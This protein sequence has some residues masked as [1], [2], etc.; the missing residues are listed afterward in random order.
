M[1]IRA[2]IRTAALATL[3][4]SGLVPAHAAD[5]SATQVIQVAASEGTSRFVPLGVGK[6]V[7]I[8]LPRDIKDVLVANPKIA[9]A[10]VR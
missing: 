8:D 1:A 2:S 5:T 10:V 4:L 9:N 6:S 7:A 3:I